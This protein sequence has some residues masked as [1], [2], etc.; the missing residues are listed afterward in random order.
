MGRSPREAPPQAS[1]AGRLERF[2]AGLLRG[3]A[4][5]RATV[6]RVVE[7]AAAAPL[8]NEYDPDYDDDDDDDAAYEAALRRGPGGGRR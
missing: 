7:L 1:A 8:P 4:L 2:V 5:V 3:P 6:L